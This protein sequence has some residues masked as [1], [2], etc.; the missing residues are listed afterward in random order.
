MVGWKRGAGQCEGG[1]HSCAAK[2]KCVGGSGRPA[3][4]QGARVCRAGRGHLER[5]AAV[6]TQPLPT[7]GVHEVQAILVPCRRQLLMRLLHSP[8]G[9]TAGQLLAAAG[10]QH[11]G[12]PPV[13]SPRQAG[14][15]ME[16]AE[17]WLRAG[18]GR[19]GVMR[20]GGQAWAPSQARRGPWGANSPAPCS[21]C[22]RSSYPGSTLQREA[23]SR[24]QATSE[25][26]PRL[27]TQCSHSGAVAAIEA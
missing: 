14:M 11:P 13:P 9:S 6:R 12:P 27:P 8:G 5:C 7:R 4:S 24:A 17:S 19:A 25:L 18:T 2:K 21:G 10:Q 3:G 16:Q 26:D 23:G 22:P 20:C 15:R 1:G